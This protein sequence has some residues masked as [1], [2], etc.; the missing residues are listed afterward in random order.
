MLQ[1]FMNFVQIDEEIITVV[2]M[3]NH[4]YH[5]SNKNS[6]KS[7]IKIT[8]TANT[9]LKVSSSQRATDV[10]VKGK[11]VFS[12]LGFIRNRT[13]KVIILAAPL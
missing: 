11:L 13:V 5:I 8:L 7:L 3:N 6:I 10:E 1:E 12:G 9:R 2:I 4:N